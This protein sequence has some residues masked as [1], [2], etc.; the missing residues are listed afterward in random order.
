MSDC[1]VHGGWYFAYGS[2][3][4]PERLR[5]R[6]GDWSDCRRAEL[7]GWRLRFSDRVQSEGGGGAVVE[8]SE[9]GVVHGAVFHGLEGRLCEAAVGAPLLSLEQPLGTKQASDVV[10][11][12]DRLHGA[13]S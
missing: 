7:E 9:G 4:D 1:R 8:P 12:I 13:R 3:L 10:S 5:R 6:V 2:N 11:A